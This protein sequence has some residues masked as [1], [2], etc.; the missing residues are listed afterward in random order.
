MES[1]P[2]SGVEIR[3]AVVDAFDA[4]ARR[5]PI[6][7]GMTPHEH[8]GKGAPMSAALITVSGVFFPKCFT[9]KDWGMKALIKPAMVNPSNSHGADSISRRIKLLKSVCIRKSIFMM[10]CYSSISF[11]CM[12]LF[13]QCNFLISL[14]SLQQWGFGASE[15]PLCPLPQ[16][17]YI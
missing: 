9:N 6:A 10:G 1:T 3:K 7:A 8:K 17:I 5:R 14:V 15:S 4:P 11:A 16:S 12:V 13:L 2:V